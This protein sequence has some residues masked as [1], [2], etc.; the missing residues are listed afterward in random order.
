MNDTIETIYL[1]ALVMKYQIYSV[2]RIDHILIMVVPKDPDED[3]FGWAKL[4]K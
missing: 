3:D 4:N 2:D 1:I